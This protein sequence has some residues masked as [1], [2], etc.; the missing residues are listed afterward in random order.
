[1]MVFMTVCAFVVRH[2]QYLAP[3]RLAIGFVALLA[4]D[5]DVLAPK[6]EVGNI[7]IELLLTHFTPTGRN[8]A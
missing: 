4:F 5:R 1:M 2:L 6:L 8:M 3:R 7:M